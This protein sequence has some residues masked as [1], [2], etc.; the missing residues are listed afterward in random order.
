MPPRPHR[1]THDPN[2]SSVYDIIHILALPSFAARTTRIGTSRILQVAQH[3]AIQY[4]Y[5]LECAYVM[6]RW[7]GITWAQIDLTHNGL[8]TGFVHGGDYVYLSEVAIIERRETA[9]VGVNGEVRNGVSEDH[10]FI[11]T[12]NGA[13]GEGDPS[14]AGQVLVNGVDASASATRVPTTAA[15]DANSTVAG[16]GDAPK[17]PIPAVTVQD[18][19]HPTDG[20]R[21]ELRFHY[22]LLSSDRAAVLAYHHALR[23]VGLTPR[24]EKNA[25]CGPGVVHRFQQIP[26]PSERYAMEAVDN[27]L[28]YFGLDGRVEAPVSTVLGGGDG[29]TRGTEGSEIREQSRAGLGH[30]RGREGGGEVDQEGHAHV[31]RGR[32]HTWADPMVRSVA[33]CGY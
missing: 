2:S 13:N 4:L 6:Q 24:D 17:I 14:V 22:Q 27:G 12:R 19:D 1:R 31:Y 15:R 21:E 8:V 32:R 23:F 11:S 25:V 10:G 30:G 9:P 5:I 18:L 33:S 3:R 29:K 16:P 7:H 20:S 26:L 28:R